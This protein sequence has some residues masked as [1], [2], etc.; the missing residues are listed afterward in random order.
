M[1]W[2]PT[3]FFTLFYKQLLRTFTFLY[4]LLNTFDFVSSR[5]KLIVRT[6]QGISKRG[7]KGGGLPLK[8][9]E[10]WNSCGLESC[11]WAQR[12]LGASD[13][14]PSILSGV[15]KPQ[16]RWFLTFLHF[17]IVSPAPRHCTFAILGKKP[18]I[19]SVVQKH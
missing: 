11:L 18:Y 3:A 16:R 10:K 12:G 5:P 7:G 15:E 6:V 9:K 1:L 8:N 13:L 14:L 2:L 4:W 19:P 17:Y